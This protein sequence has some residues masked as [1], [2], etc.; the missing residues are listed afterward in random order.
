MRYSTTIHLP[1][2]L[3]SYEYMLQTN[4]EVAS[5]CTAELDDGDDRRPY[6]AVGTMFYDSMEK[7]PSRGRVLLFD[8]DGFYSARKGGHLIA[9]AE[10]KGCAYALGSVDGKLV[11]AVNTGVSSCRLLSFIPLNNFS[12]KLILMSLF[13]SSQSYNTMELKELYTWNHNYL[14]TT[15]A[16]KDKHIIIGDAVNSVAVLRLA[17]NRFDVIARD[18]GP[19]WPLALEASDDTS[20]IGANVSDLIFPEICRLTLRADSL[21]RATTTFLL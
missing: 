18:Y 13:G 2:I 6:F 1:L 20:I 5:L 12:L 17:E 14:V 21:Q 3:V 15:L 16:I 8:V 10:I 11:V 19:L 4:E 7:E 9:S